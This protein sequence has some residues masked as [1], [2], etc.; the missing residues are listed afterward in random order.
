MRGIL[1]KLTPDNRIIHAAVFFRALIHIFS[2]LRY[3]KMYVYCVRL[4]LVHC[5]ILFA[6]A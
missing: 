2:P 4:D 6:R 3:S 5:P 1:T